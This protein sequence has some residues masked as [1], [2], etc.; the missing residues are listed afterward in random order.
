MQTI[1]RNS[2]SQPSPLERYRRKLAAQVEAQ[3]S[4]SDIQATAKVVRSLEAV[5]VP[6]RFMRK[7]VR[8]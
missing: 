3:A 7:E 6:F 2:H 8:S 1:L 4:E 5:H